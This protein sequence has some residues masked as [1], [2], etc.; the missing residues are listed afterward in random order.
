[1][2]LILSQGMIL[3]YDSVHKSDLWVMLSVLEMSVG[4]CMTL[5]NTPLTNGIVWEL[6]SHIQTLRRRIRIAK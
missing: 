1:M 6:G 5:N 4:G 2:M 3:K